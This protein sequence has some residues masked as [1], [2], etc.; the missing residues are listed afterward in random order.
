[1]ACL[2]TILT[3][4]INLK[5]VTFLC[6]VD[7]QK[8][9]DRVDHCKLISI[10]QDR[11][12]PI[13]EK[14]LLIEIYAEQ[15]GYMKEDERRMHPIKIG[16]GVRQGCALSPILYNTYADHVVKNLCPTIG[17][18]TGYMKKINRLAYADDTVLMA[19]SI[20][21]LEVL[22]DEMSR[23]GKEYNIEMNMG[24][25]KMMMVL[26]KGK[27][28][29]RSK[30]NIEKVDSFSYLGIGI[31]ENMPHDKDIRSSLEKARA[32]F[33][34]NRELLRHNL[35][36]RCKKQLLSTQVFSVVRYCSE[37]FTLTNLLKK[38]IESFE[39]WCYRRIL[40]IAWTEKVTNVEVIRRMKMDSSK[41]LPSILRRKCIYL[42]H[43]ARGSAGETLKNLCLNERKIGKGRKRRRW[44]D[45]LEEIAGDQKGFALRSANA[46]DRV[47]WRIKIRSRWPGL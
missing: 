38:K 9:F 28:P 20:E 19:E 45:D 11:E 31:G 43:V 39:M 5:Q 32:S 14:E 30:L 12:V 6:F 36:L 24:K 22:I 37:A 16:R 17:I 1:V 44:T 13:R 10:L 26:Q 23:L 27:E 7:F 33:W 18:E 41:L 40:K 42:G 25:T 35:S 4:R 46:G 2:K 3:N 15:V 8:A 47:Q 29:Y 21:D 34:R